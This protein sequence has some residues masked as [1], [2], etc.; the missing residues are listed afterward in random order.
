M[1][2][3]NR[4]IKIKQGPTTAVYSYK[5]SGDTAG[6]RITHKEPKPVLFRNGRKL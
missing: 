2:T 3:P 4:Y 6:V 1:K 5:V